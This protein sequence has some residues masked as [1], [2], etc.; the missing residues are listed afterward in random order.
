MSNGVLIPPP[1]RTRLRRRR[2]W[3]VETSPWMLWRIGIRSPASGA[4][5]ARREG[6]FNS[7]RPARWRDCVAAHALRSVQGRLHCRRPPSG[8]PCAPYTCEHGLASCVARPGEAAS[9]PPLAHLWLLASVGVGDGAHDGDHDD[10][11]HAEPGGA[12]ASARGAGRARG[13]CAGGRRAGG[14]LL[15]RARPLTGRRRAPLARVVCGARVA[16]WRVR[17]RCAR[18]RGALRAAR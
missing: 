10:H 11:D 2:A 14:L 13:P 5:G 18:A 7:G 16:R 12:L 8:P 4:N 9:L 3:G 1:R 15:A 6:G 17:A